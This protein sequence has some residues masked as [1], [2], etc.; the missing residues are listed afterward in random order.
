MHSIWRDN[1]PQ[2]TNPLKFFVFVSGPH[3]RMVALATACV[4]V[5][6]VLGALVPYLYKIIIDSAVEMSAGS[7]D[8][9]WQAIVAYVVIVLASNLLWRGSGFAGM[10]W[11]TGVRATARGALNS[12]V[13]KHS[14]QYFSERFAGAISNKIKQAGDGMRDFVE[15]YLRQ[16][17]GFIISVIAIFI[18]VFSTSPV[19]GLLLGLF[20]VITPLNFYLAR[21]RIPLSYAA[22]SAETNLNGAS[23]DMLTNITAVHDYARR[24]YELERL[25]GLIDVRRTA[26][27][28]NWGYGEWVLVT[29]NIIQAVFTG[30]MLLLAVFL[31]IRGEITPGDIILFLAMV[32]L[33]ESQLTF[34]GS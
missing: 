17:L 19:V 21:R 12:Y 15:A 5:A 32:T 9:L 1:V 33:L 34:I 25:M 22:Q 26:G 28:R 11:A 16:F 10:R 27:L 13:T 23:V 8:A 24:T 31:A 20:V 14:H 29:N 30:A 4:V 3:W 7:Y 18:V 6:S 2:T